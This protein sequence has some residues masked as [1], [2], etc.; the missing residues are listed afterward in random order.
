MFVDELRRVFVR[1]RN[2][3][4]LILVAVVP[5][6]L[7]VIVKVSGGPHG[8]GGPPFFAE[9]TQNAIF[10]PLA[11]L[12]SME[13]LLIPL[14]VSV[15]A[16]DSVAGDA[17]NGSLRYLLIRRAGRVRI[18]NAKLV[19][20]LGFAVAVTLVVVGVGL[21]AGFLLFPHHVL[22]TLSGVPVSTGV[23]IAYALEA[24]GVVAISVASVVTIGVLF[25]TFTSSSL[26]A[27]SLAVTVTI[28]SEVLD[29]IP[30]VARIHPFLLT[31]YWF[32]FVDLFRSPQV[33]SAIGRN[34]VEQVGWALVAYLFAAFNLRNKDILS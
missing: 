34:V 18:L 22:V 17:A 31:N 26:A 16:G 11:A 4:I 23:G 27:T 19:A 7:G 21:I 12:A 20:A 30:Q 29:A 6:L 10:L 28:A 3:I 14:A 5:V 13:T 24:A 15:V 9:I 25:S 8:G 32:S 1:P 33:T 2:W